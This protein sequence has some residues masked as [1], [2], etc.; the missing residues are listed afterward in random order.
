MFNPRSPS[1][2]GRRRIGRACQQRRATSVFAR[3]TLGA[4]LTE[5]TMRS[6]NSTG[7]RSTDRGAQATLSSRTDLIRWRQGPR[8]DRQACGDEAGVTTMNGARP[9]ADDPA[10]R[11]EVAAEERSPTGP[12][13]RKTIA[14]KQTRRCT[15]IEPRPYEQAGGTDPRAGREFGARRGAWRVEG[16]RA[17]STKHLRCIQ[18]VSPAGPSQ[19][20]QI[21]GGNS[22][23]LLQSQA[24]DHLLA[25]RHRHT[26]PRRDADPREDPGLLILL[27]VDP[28][29]RQPVEPQR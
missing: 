26:S 22:D 1:D 4:E 10:W 29:R 3:A 2:D 6:G 18:P 28:H 17:P 14:I 11:E 23:P 21:D 5:L 24:L 25:R 7:P 15:N 13:P 19:P 9:T 20:T 12:E 16:A 8:R 27:V